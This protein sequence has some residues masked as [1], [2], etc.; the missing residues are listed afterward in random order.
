MRDLAGSAARK[1]G[2]TAA[3]AS[4]REIVVPV[5]GTE[6]LLVLTALETLT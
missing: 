1:R 3:L 4:R 6:H 5:P 2:G